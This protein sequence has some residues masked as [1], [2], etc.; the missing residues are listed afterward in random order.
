MTIRVNDKDVQ[1]LVRYAESKLWT[2]TRTG[3]HIRF[4]SPEGAT[5]IA[6][7]TSSDWRGFKNTVAEL[8]RAGLEVP[9]K[10]PTKKNKREAMERW[11]E[12]AFTLPAFK[13]TQFPHITAILGQWRNP[14]WFAEDDTP[15]TEEQWGEFT[16]DALAQMVMGIYLTDHGHDVVPPERKFRMTLDAY[17]FWVV[18]SEKLDPD[19]Q[20]SLTRCTCGKD[21]VIGTGITGLAAHIVERHERCDFDHA[22]DAVSLSTWEDP[23]A[24]AALMDDSQDR[25]IERLEALVA[26][27]T[28]E[29]KMTN[30]R[31]AQI[32][33]RVLAVF[34]EDR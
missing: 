24:V 13:V 10:A 4:I 2:V 15:L 34:D 20:D 22:P 9:R 8:R 30:A 27:L 19:Q 6:P 16:E 33:Q 21:F 12:P 31:L 3:S 29:V 28:Q 17:K 25:E 1:V 11:V 5:V 23:I 32:K 7:S 26:T 18:G 14:S